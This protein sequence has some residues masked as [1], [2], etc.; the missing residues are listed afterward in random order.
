MRCAVMAVDLENLK[1]ALR[2]LQGARNKSLTSNHQNAVVLWMSG[3]IHWMNHQRVEGIS[4][5]QAA[6][7][8]FKACGTNNHMDPDRKGWY[9]DKMRELDG[10]L[11]EAIRIGG[12]PIFQRPAAPPDPSATASQPPSGPN[13]LSF[14]SDSLRWVS[15]QVSEDVPAGGFGPTGFDPDPS[16]FLEISEVVIG[17]EAYNI[18]SVKRTAANF[19]HA[20]EINSQRR[21]QTVHVTGTSMNAAI[22]VPIEPGDYVL[23]VSQ[24]VVEDNEIVVAGILDQDVRATVKR[25]CR[26]NGRIQLKPESSDE[27]NYQFD[28]EKEYDEKLGD[29]FE[30]IGVVEAV[31]KKKS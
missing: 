25:F 10:Y 9:T 11:T 22:P 2:L 3:C 20:V 27:S 31:F 18:L 26:R 24:P 1:D 7:Q 14:E 4:D 13:N 28:W 16:G 17:G 6:I 15:C 23:I 21:Y 19:R 8:A 29:Q 30:I 12:L 5:W